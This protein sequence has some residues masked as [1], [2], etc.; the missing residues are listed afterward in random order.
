VNQ[1]SGR[2]EKIFVNLEAVYPTPEISGSEMSFE[3]LRASSRGWLHKQWKPE[4]VD[5]FVLEDAKSSDT[6]PQPSS[7]EEGEDVVLNQAFA[8]K[9]VIPRDPLIL[10]E[11]G[12]VSEAIREGRSRKLKTVEVNETQ[13]SM[14]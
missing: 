4:R 6:N 14:M 5:T 9:L 2:Q 7:F 12:A 10:D 8:E 3:E 1:R 13:I 11:N